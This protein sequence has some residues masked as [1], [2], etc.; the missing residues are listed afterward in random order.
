MECDEYLE[1]LII[2]DPEDI[3]VQLFACLNINGGIKCPKPSCPAVY[4]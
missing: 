2:N 4:D 3:D 1:W